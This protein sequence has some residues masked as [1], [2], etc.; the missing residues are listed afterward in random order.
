[1]QAVVADAFATTSI[2]IGDLAWL[3]RDH[4]HRE[5]SL[6]ISLW[7]D[8]DGRL[9]GWTYFRSNGEFNFLVAPGFVD[10]SLVDEMLTTV[11]EA[12]EAQIGAGDPP[13][14]L[15]TYGI[16]RDRSEQDRVA[17]EALQRHGFEPFE[18]GGALVRSLDDVPDP[19]LPPGYRLGFVRENDDVIGRVE[20]QRAAFTRSRLTL[21]TYERVR[22]AWP[23]RAELD[24]V[25][26]ADDG[27]IVAFCTAWIDDQNASGLLEPVGSHPAHRRRGLAKAACLDALLALRNAGSRTA[28]VG[29]ETDAALATYRSIGFEPRWHEMSFRRPVSHPMT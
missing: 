14:V 19:A 2:R 23:Y 26:K 12:W 1:M 10:K 15:S 21:Q 24:R 25:V 5:L 18:Q 20:A 8:R 17:A 6:D 4:T 9:I 29:Y 27:A 3:M 13:V 22:S 16:D 28:Q 7:E 11:D